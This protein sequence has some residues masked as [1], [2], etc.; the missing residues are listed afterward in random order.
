MTLLRSLLISIF[1]YWLAAAW[2]ATG[3]VLLVKLAVI[4]FLIAVSYLVAGEFWELARLH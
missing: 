2:P 1:A 4:T 3:L